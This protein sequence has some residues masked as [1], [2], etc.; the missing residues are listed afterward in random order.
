MEGTPFDEFLTELE[1]RGKSKPSKA[2]K[3]RKRKKEGFAL[4]RELVQSMEEM[5]EDMR[6]R[7]R[8]LTAAEKMKLEKLLQEMPRCLPARGDLHIVTK[9][10][11]T[12]KWVLTSRLL[13]EPEF[14]EEDDLLETLLGEEP[15]PELIAF[16]LGIAYGRLTAEGSL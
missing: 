16:S 10:L 8:P 7:F 3:S 2:A 5:D 14:G 11:A 15:T 4:A 9:L 13:F 1:G 6:R 12:L